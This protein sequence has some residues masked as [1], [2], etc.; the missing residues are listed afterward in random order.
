MPPKKVR[1]IVT[2][3][4]VPRLLDDKFMAPHLPRRADGA[5]F[6]MAV[7]EAASTY[8]AERAVPT[9]KAVR[10]EIRG[11]YSAAEKRRYKEVARRLAALSER[12]HAFLSKRARRFSVNVVIPAPEDLADPARRGAACDDLVR[13]LRVGMTKAGRAK[14]FEPN[15]PRRPSRRVAEQNFVMRLELIFANA[16]GETALTATGAL[17]TAGAPVG[18]LARLAQ[19]CFDTLVGQ[20][21]V[22]AVKMI[23]ALHAKRLWL[24][25]VVPWGPYCKIRTQEVIV[26]AAD[27]EPTR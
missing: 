13:L 19:A 4:D 11:L 21:V 14:L 12:T 7:R 1:H 3:G 27:A 23:N 15:V 2:P 25:G 8:A 9:E 16:T 6:T 10:D 26:P 22:N 20:G 5:R 24:L 17:T 18:P